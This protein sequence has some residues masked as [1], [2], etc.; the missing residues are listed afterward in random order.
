MLKWK[1]RDATLIPYL[2]GILK[3]ENVYQLKV[4]LF[5]YKIKNDL[6]NIPTIFHRTLTQASEI[7]THNNRFASK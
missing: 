5:T 4:P 1:F 7:Y 6:T 2:L 3:F